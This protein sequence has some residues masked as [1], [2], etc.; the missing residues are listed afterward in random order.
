M[1]RGTAGW[2]ALK[3]LLKGVADE[4]WDIVDDSM[5]QVEALLA[6]RPRLTQAEARRLI[7]GKELPPCLAR[8]GKRAAA[9]FS[10]IIAEMW[11]DLEECYLEWFER[12]PSAVE[13]EAL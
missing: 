6:G 9:K 4:P 1:P 3:V 13:K 11:E 12:R 5:R 8:L 7:R 2:H 10:R